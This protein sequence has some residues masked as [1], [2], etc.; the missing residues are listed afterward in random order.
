MV[1]YKQQSRTFTPEEYL[2]LE[3]RSNY[4]SEELDG[5]IYAMSGGSPEHS[6]I[7]N[8]V[9]AELRAQLKGRPCT[10]FNSD[11]K[12]RT[13]PAG[14]FAY[15]D[16]TVACG[17]LRFHDA[18]RDLLTNPIVI[19]EVLS[20][21]TEAYDRGEKFLNYQAIASLQT[22]V[23]IAQHQARVE[24]F[25]RQP[26]G[27]WLYSPVTGRDQSFHIASIDCTLALSEIYDR[28][29][30]PVPPTNMNLA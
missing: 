29:A 9:G 7:A 1:A 30:F 15:P 27:D 11:M 16:V 19:V 20:S 2:E 21:S 4:K 22:Y 28:I 12:V 25:V 6:I 26:N 23:L 17:E 5:Q 8:N 10:T 18:H 3:R 24:Q 13:S 14:L